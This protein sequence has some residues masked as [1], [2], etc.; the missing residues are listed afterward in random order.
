[1]QELA[2]DGSLHCSIQIGIRKDHQGRVTAEIQGNVLE[3]LSTGGK[4][5]NVLPDRRRPR[6]RNQARDRMGDEVIT[7]LGSGAH[8]HVEHSGWQSRF[9]EHPR[10]MSIE[11]YRTRTWA[12][13]RSH[14]R[15]TSPC[16]RF[17]GYS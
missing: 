15:T 9:L 6:E 5:A 17:S 16:E 4:F 3:V 10:D 12:C 13:S 14:P 2:H 8:H 1:M 7:D 11:T